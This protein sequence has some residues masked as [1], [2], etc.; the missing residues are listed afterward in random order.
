M[1]IGELCSEEDGMGNS[2]LKLKRCTEERQLDLIRC[3]QF[4][5]ERF[6]NDNKNAKKSNKINNK[7]QNG[8]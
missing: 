8:F 2:N 3:C 7:R 1:G 5:E 6:K 4:T